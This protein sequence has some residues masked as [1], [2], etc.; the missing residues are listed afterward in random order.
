MK[1]WLHPQTAY[2]HIPFCAHHC[3]YCD[4]AVAIAQEHQIDLYLEALEAELST[5]KN[6]HPLPMR[7]IGGGTP[8][9]LNLAQLTQ[10][11]YILE[12][13]VPLLPGGEF[14]IESTP[15]SLNREKVQLLQSHG[16]TRVSIGIQTFHD[17]LLPVLER[18]HHVEQIAPSIELVREQG[19]QCSL[20][21]I[22]AVP[23][24]TLADWQSDIDRAL[25]YQPDHLSTYGLTY[26]KGTPLWKQRE[27]GQ[28][29]ALDEELE[30]AMYQ[31][32]MEKLTQAGY[33]HYE[34][35][36]FMKPGS[37]CRH[38]EVYWANHA[39]YGFGMGAAGYLHGTRHVNSRSLHDYIKRALSGDDT[40]FQREQLPPRERA[41]ETIAVQLRRE[42]GIERGAFQEQTEFDLNVL[43]G[44]E[45]GR[46]AELKLLTVSEENISLTPAGKCVADGVIQQLMKSQ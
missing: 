10:L 6:P 21:L 41:F 39:H 9:H 43:V 14:S 3:G 46:L 28:V 44:D 11:L 23:G 13:W 18:R 12:R 37:A 27:R 15:D 31:M 22:F 19:L 16:L 29:H 33:I 32:G 8:T 1:P 30:L 2:V 34:I 17:H 4:F 26:E 7:F 36:N 5:L 42:R 25:T 24:Q 45:C 40:A 20:D 38:N 35:S